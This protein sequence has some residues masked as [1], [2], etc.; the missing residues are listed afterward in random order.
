MDRK[1]REQSQGA[2]VDQTPI[3]VIAKNQLNCPTLRTLLQI[4]RRDVLSLSFT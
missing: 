3:L 4:S 1:A 2:I